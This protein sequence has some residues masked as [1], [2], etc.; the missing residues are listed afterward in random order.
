ML[1]TLWETHTLHAGLPCHPPT[2]YTGWYLVQFLWSGRGKTLPHTMWKCG[3]SA[4]IDATTASPT[5]QDPRTTTVIAIVSYSVPW[6]K[7]HMLLNWLFKGNIGCSECH[8][9][10]LH[11]VLLVLHLS[12]Q[13]TWGV[14]DSSR[15]LVCSVAGKAQKRGHQKFGT[16]VKCLFLHRKTEKSLKHLR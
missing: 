12:S 10:Y 4:S 15:Y 13:D 1:P 8:R 6:K 9:N 14:T 5:P 11:N 7:E 2:N 16:P 3:S